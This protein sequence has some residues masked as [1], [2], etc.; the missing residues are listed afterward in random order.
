M[1]FQDLQSWSLANEIFNISVCID[2]VPTKNELQK[3]FLNN[4]Y[5]LIKPTNIITLEECIRNI[6]DC[7]FTSTR[8]SFNKEILKINLCKGI[9]HFLINSHVEI[10]DVNILIT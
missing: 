8:H 3:V 10:V 9:N 4:P 2:R 7:M 6:S 1:S 5:F